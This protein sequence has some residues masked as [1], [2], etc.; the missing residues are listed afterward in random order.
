MTL[1]REKW[2]ELCEAI[3][4]ELDP[5]KLSKLAAQLVVALDEQKVGAAP[6]VKV[7]QDESPKPESGSGIVR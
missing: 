6:R 5:E 2:R 3:V 7:I 1:E 4:K